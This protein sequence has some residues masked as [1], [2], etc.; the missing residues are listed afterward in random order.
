MDYD[1][2]GLCADQIENL[3]KKIVSFN[4]KLSKDYVFCL[5]VINDP[6]LN[7]RKSEI[8]SEINE[9]LLSQI[10]RVEIFYT[11]A[12]NKIQRV[13]KGEKG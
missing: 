2:A 10:S 8:V 9:I 3:S 4:K 6:E 7:K 5:N 12:L 1:F 11:E 13:I